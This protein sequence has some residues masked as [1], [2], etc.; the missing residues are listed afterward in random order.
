[1]SLLLWILVA[2][3]LAFVVVRQRSVAIGLITLQALAL[4]GLALHEAVGP[5]G[6]VAACAL[7]VRAVALAAVFL[8][9][10]S[11][12][13][14]SRPVRARTGPSIRAVAAVTFALALTWLLPTLGLTTRDAERAVIALVAFGLVAVATRHATILQIMGIVLAENGLAIAAL[15]RPHTLSHVIALG[16]AF[17]LTIIAFVAAAFH[18]RIFDEFG[19]GDSAVLRSLR[20]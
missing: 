3:G 18:S 12:T 14:E 8:F 1:M 20:D 7:C 10:A 9:V 19:T 17:D 2:L 13:R 11:R 4:V 16:V 6:I 5:S 15:A